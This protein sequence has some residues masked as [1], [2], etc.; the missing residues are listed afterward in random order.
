MR[1][2]VIGSGGREHALVWKLSQSPA[3]EKIFCAPGNAG[4]ASLAECVPLGPE[5]IEKLQIFAR[6]K[7]IHLT[8]VGP[9]APL[10]AG[11]TDLF[12]ENGQLIFG[13]GRKGARLEGSKVW[14]KE[15]MVKH[16][17]PTADFKVFEDA[18]KTY[19][20]LKKATYPLVIKADGLAGGKG[21]IVAADEEKARR[22]V[23]SL[24]EAK[25]FGAAGA[26]VIVEEYLKGEEVSVFAITDGERFYPLAA[27]QDHKALYEGDRGPNTGGMGSYS[28][29]PV[30]TE[31]LA[32]AVNRDIF[33]P[34][35]TGLRQ[36]GIDYRGIIF[37]GLMITTAG[38]AKV[39]EF[40][41][42]FGDPE[43]QVLLPRL[44][45]D[46]LP[47][48]YEAARGN[49]GAVSPP[50][51]SVDT[52]LCVVL[53]SRGYPGEYEKGK[54]ITGL[55]KVQD[56]KNTA[57]FH[58]GTAFKDNH[59]VTAGG[60]VLGVT[61]WAFSLQEARDRAYQM[62]EMIDF[63]GKYFRRDIGYRALQGGI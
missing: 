9:E 27:V 60:R 28:P 20:F 48:L 10:V 44:Q 3:V 37:G 26:R 8:V 35:L 39:L 12:Q 14:A 42:R 54:I 32:A 29:P 6:E 16:G 15:F 36:E 25:A 43:A 17:I 7:G 34:L 30:L 49:L 58:A 46:L 11:I 23:Y 38:E 50:V 51:W 19:R 62:A 21:V 40:N 57:V 5:E 31:Q 52:A 41:V 56:F 47:L 53:A 18:E 63:E 59:L 24:M 2:L 61:A 1:V 45:S 33:E 55:E 22:A 4:I 13:P